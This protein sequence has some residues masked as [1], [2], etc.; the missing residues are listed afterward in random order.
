M[1]AGMDGGGGEMAAAA[2]AAAVT[3][4]GGGDGG[5]DG[6]GGW[7]GGDGGLRRGC[8]LRR[9]R[10]RVARSSS[11][12]P[13]Q[14]PR[15][16]PSS[17]PSILTVASSSPRV[18]PRL[19]ITTGRPGLALCRTN[20]S[21]DI[22]VSDEPSTTSTSAASTSAYACST[23]SRGTDSPKKTT[24][25]LSRPPQSAQSARTKSRHSLHHGVAVR[26]QLGV[27]Q[28]GG[29][30]D[31]GVERGEP[32][33]HRRPAATAAAVQA[34]HRGDVAV[35]VDHRA[36][37]G[38]LVQA[39]DV[40]GDHPGQPGRPLQLD[41]RP[42]TGVGLGLADP[43]PAQV[44]PGPVAPLRLGGPD[45]LAELHRRGPDRGR[46]AVVRDARSRWRCPRRSAR[47][48]SGRGAGRPQPP[49]GRSPEPPSRLR[50]YPAGPTST[51]RRPCWAQ[52][53]SAAPRQQPVLGYRNLC[54]HR[55]RQW[56][57]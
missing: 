19:M 42:V 5:G 37:A 44:G 46:P 57:G 16:S 29:R 17:P 35:Q 25:G 27:L 32:T 1:T 45:E 14:G 3:V 22:T 55:L 43:P 7:F 49:P 34:D 38:R 20:R 13:R 36:A 40:L 33:L 41:Q 51:C 23:R 31:V 12:R 24:S 15:A 50:I 26:P 21:P 18:G 54:A 28:P 52:L 39:V 8:R 2:T 47:P 10:R 11:R 30:R 56:G 6:G 53:W 9:L 4:V 48:R